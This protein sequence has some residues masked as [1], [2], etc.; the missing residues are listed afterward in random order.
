MNKPTNLIN[1]MLVGIAAAFVGAMLRPDSPDAKLRY[2]IVSSVVW[3]LITVAWEVWQWRKSKMSLRTYWQR[4]G[5]D[6]VLDLLVGNAAFLL[7][8][9]VMT[10]GTYQGNVLRP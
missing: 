3:A 8:F 9:W 4:K 10:L 5:V 2:A 7:P 6:T 1:H